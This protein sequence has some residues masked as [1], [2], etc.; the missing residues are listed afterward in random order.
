MTSTD[1]PP[2]AAACCGLGCGLGG[3]RAVRQPSPFGHRGQQRVDADGF[4]FGATMSTE[5]PADGAGHFDSDLVGFQL[6]E[7]FID[8][9]ASPGFLNHVATVAS[10][11]L[12][13]RVGT[14]TSVSWLVL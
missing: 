8:R 10:V 12:S 13:P 3:L 14:R 2:Y 11:T 1:S 7:H 9:D 5:V 6:A 4:A